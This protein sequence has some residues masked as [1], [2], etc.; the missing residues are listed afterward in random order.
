MSK[1]G[2]SFSHYSCIVVPKGH[3]L[4][5]TESV[6]TGMHSFHRYWIGQFCWW[7]MWKCILVCNDQCNKGVLQETLMVPTGIPLCSME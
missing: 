1:V 5:I 7:K 4:R 2:K 6:L 3:D